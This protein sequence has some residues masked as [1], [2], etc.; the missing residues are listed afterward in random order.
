MTPNRPHTDPQSGHESN[1]AR[2]SGG[3]ALLL[4]LVMLAL[5]AVTIGTLA[6]VSSSE[7]LRARQAERDLQ[8]RW[9]E[10]SSRRVLLPAL[11]QRLESELDAWRTSE[12]APTL[13]PPASITVTLDLGDQRIAARVD[14]LQALPNLNRQLAMTKPGQRNDVRSIFTGGMVHER[15]Q[16]R[17]LEE[18]HARRMGSGP[19]LSWGQLYPAAGPETLSGL[20]PTAIPPGHFVY[21][22]GNADPT[23][24]NPGVG[25]TL[26]GDGKLNVWT[27]S[28]DSLHRVLDHSIGSDQTTRLIEL[29]GGHRGLSARELIQM[30]NLGPSE[31]AAARLALTDRTETYALWLAITPLQRGETGPDGRVLWSL[32]VHDANNSLSQ[33]RLRGQLRGRW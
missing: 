4:T 18:D 24:F 26:W 30:M 19:Y 8:S 25:W 11:Q 6:H 23:G 17:P 15:L 16:P 9:A 13:P 1:W 31:R 2:R 3:Y 12:Q 29:R 32:T 20:D 22:N 33:G 10:T 5:T 27:A 7:A 14:D 21:A 28:Q